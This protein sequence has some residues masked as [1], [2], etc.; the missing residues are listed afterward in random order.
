MGF[1]SRVVAAIDT[2]PSAD[3]LRADL[4]LAGTRRFLPDLCALHL[5]VRRCAAG[6]AVVLP[7]CRLDLVQRYGEIAVQTT[8]TVSG[9][10]EGPQHRHRDQLRLAQRPCTEYNRA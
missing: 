1:A 4:Q 2:R 3:L 8:A 6:Q 10:P 7:A 9:L 5:L